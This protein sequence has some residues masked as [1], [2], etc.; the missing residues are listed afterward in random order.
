MGFPPGCQTG[1]R[2]CRALAAM[3]Q[4]P[5]DFPQSQDRP[6]I[7]R[8]LESPIGWL[9]LAWLLFHIAAVALADQA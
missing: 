4:G 9:A 1:R 3:P 7:W 6:R 8:R 5:L 2:A